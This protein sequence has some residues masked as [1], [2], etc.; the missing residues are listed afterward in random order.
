V[1]SQQFAA[2]SAKIDGLTTAIDVLTAVVTDYIREQ[3]SEYPTQPDL[4]TPVK[5][6]PAK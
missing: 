4:K 2:L 3:R 6:E 1:T 5:R